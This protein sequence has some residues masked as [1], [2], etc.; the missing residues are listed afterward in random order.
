MSCT[1]FDEIPL[2]IIFRGG[3]GARARLAALATLTWV[4]RAVK[5]GVT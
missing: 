3:V 2:A 4:T 5:A 1:V